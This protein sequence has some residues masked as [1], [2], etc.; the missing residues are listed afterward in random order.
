MRLIPWT[1][2]IAPLAVIALVVLP[3]RAV[4]AA[5]A[6]AGHVSSGEASARAASQTPSITIVSPSNGEVVAGP[7]VTLRWTATG[8]EVVAAALATRQD[9]THFHVFVDLAPDLMQTTP[10]TTEAFHTGE[11]E[12]RLDNLAAGTHTVWVA[13]GFLDHTPFRPYAVDSVTFVV[14]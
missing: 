9:Q 3:S 14:S 2:V 6:G 5:P 4:H 7:A 10:W 12:W 13:A 1:R 8:M 11:Y